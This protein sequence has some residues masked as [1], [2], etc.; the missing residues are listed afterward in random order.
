MEHAQ[1]LPFASS[2]C[3]AC[4]EVCPV[5]I[6]IPEVLIEL[7][8]QVVDQERKQTQRAF[9]TPCISAC[10]L[11]TRFFASAWRF[12][13]A[14]RL[15]AS[16][17][18]PSPARTAGFTPCPA[19]AHDGQPPATCAVC[20]ARPSASGG[21]RSRKES[22][23]ERGRFIPP[24]RFSTRISRQRDLTEV[25]CQLCAADSPDA[26]ARLHSRPAASS[27][28]Q[29]CIAMLMVERL[30]E[31]DAEVVECAPRAHCRRVSQMHS[32]PAAEHRF[33]APPGLPADVARRWF[34]LEDRPRPR[35]RRNRTMR[36]RRDRR[37]RRH[38]RLGNHRA[39]S[40]RQRRA[41]A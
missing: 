32:H 36:R 23:N 41:G 9:S 39:A 16:A 10:G 17:C 34:R 27:A 1:S 13:A 5:K 14:Q 12:R 8:A 28:R 15:G 33:V 6:N 2:L 24:C 20:P 18:G 4:Y 30:R 29:L 19:S 35:T 7:R 22:N 26:A 40:L 25:R 38:R 31:Y 3:G 21:L 37:V 11:P